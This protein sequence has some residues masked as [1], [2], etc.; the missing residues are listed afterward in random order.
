MNHY[1]TDTDYVRLD[2]LN[3]PQI[4]IYRNGDMFD[5]IKGLPVYPQEISGHVELVSPITH[6]RIRFSYERVYGQCFRSPWMQSPPIDYKWLT[7]FGFSNYCVIREGKVFSTITG[8]YLVGNFS[9]DGYLRVLMK[10]DYGGYVTIGI[11]R[12]VAMAYI[13]NPENKPE[14][15]H[16]NGNKLDNRVENL[17][18]NWGWENVAHALK[19]GLRK[20]VLDDNTIREICCRL[21]RGDMVKSICQDLGVEK[22]SVLGIK[23]GC[24]AR[25]SKNYNIPKNRHF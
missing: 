1:H 9:F 21:E 10:C 14:V 13:P 17:E 5:E 19:H 6:D 11:H 7:P 8:D 12:V 18:W 20:S 22:H 25:I 3:L 4:R 23:S 24:H 16:I 2:Y 15:N